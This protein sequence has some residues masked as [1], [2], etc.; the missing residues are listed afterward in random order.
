MT[1]EGQMIAAAGLDDAAGAE[2]CAAVA[3]IL[4]QRPEQPS[5]SIPVWWLV[6]DGAVLIV[7]KKGGVDESQWADEA[8]EVIEEIVICL[9]PK[10]HLLQTTPSL[11]V[12]PVRPS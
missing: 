4:P 2:L 10:E 12:M 9:R 6:L 1:I 7:C 3:N 5:T 11:W 8:W